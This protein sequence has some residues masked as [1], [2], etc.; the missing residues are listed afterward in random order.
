MEDEN[1]LQENNPEKKVVPFEFTTEED[2]PSTV[3]TA[4]QPQ[5]AKHQ[6]TN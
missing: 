2:I 6:I 5:T 4:E 1:S 3:T